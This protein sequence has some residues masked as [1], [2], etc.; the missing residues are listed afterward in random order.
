MKKIALLKKMGTFVLVIGSVIILSGH[1]QMLFAAT[2]TDGDGLDDAVETNT[3]IYVSAADTGT[4]PNNRDSDADGLT[5]GQEVNGFYGNY[6]TNYTD[7]NNPD[8]DGDGL[9]DYIE[10]VNVDFQTDP[11]LVDTDGDGLT[12]GEEALDYKLVPGAKSFHTDPIEADSDCDGLNDYIEV[13]DALGYATSP[14]YDDTDDDGINDGDEVNGALG[15]V[16]NPISKDTDADGFFDKYEIDVGTDP[17]S[18]ASAPGNDTPHPVIDTQPDKS[19]NPI[20]SGVAPLAV[21]FDASESTYAND[22]RKIIRYEWNF[23]DPGS[24]ELPRVVKAFD[25]NK[26]TGFVAGHVFDPGKIG[27]GPGGTDLSGSVDAY[28]FYVGGPLT[29]TVTLT[30]TD[31]TGAQTI[32]TKDIIVQGFDTMAHKTYFVDAVAGS[33][34]NSGLSEAE[35]WQTADWAFSNSILNPENPVLPGDRILFKRG[36]EFIIQSASYLQPN[37]DDITYA[38][39]G[40][41]ERPK[42]TRAIA[43]VSYMLYLFDNN[44]KVLDLHFYCDKANHGITVRWEKYN[45]LFLRTRVEKSPG[46]SLGGSYGVFLVDSEIQHSGREATAFMPAY[47]TALLNNILTDSKEHIAYCSTL[48]KV[49]FSGNYFSGW[50]NDDHFRICGGNTPRFG[51]AKYITLTDNIFDGRNENPWALI[52]FGANGNGHQLAK[53]I[54][55]E[56]N[57]VKNGAMM[58]LIGGGNSHLVIR[59]NIFESNSAASESKICIAN[60]YGRFTVGSRDID[61]LNNTF[62]TNG[63]GSVI[64]IQDYTGEAYDKEGNEININHKG[65]RVKNN[66]IVSLNASQRAITVT[67][68]LEGELTSDNNLF[69]LPL[70]NAFAVGSSVISFADWKARPRGNDVNSINNQ[71][72]IFVAFDSMDDNDFSADGEDLFVANAPEFDLYKDAGDNLYLQE[73][74]PAIDKGEELPMVLEDFVRTPRPNGATHDIGAYEYVLA[75][76][77]Q[78][79]FYGDT[80]GDSQISAYDAALVA[81]ASVGLRTFTPEQFQAADVDGSQDLSAFDAALIARKAVGLIEKFP[82]EG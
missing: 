17:A 56:R 16:T 6:K 45:H 81:Q 71:D 27:K 58:M 5:D 44:V 59:N 48:I 30:V 19:G 47:H 37:K 7:P 79:A 50:E 2:D 64:G 25:R 26:A 15:Y 55:F 24:S 43:G 23:N 3:G 57:I 61:I 35:P 36:C 9:T 41:G 77:P 21:F 10:G 22:G 33:D 62:I 18:N 40:S 49:A 28:G 1:T 8:T 38:S 76:S 69:F 67:E 66:I 52:H 51:P 63:I 65:I 34:T 73:T 14:F 68:E 78:V 80:D 54:L 82:V 20:T 12:D 29:Y 75:T 4:D 32:L 70:S 31:E 74:S 39:Y 42:F 11:V 72:S 46:I 13:K 60:H 53:H